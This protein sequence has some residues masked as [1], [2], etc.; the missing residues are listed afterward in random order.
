MF[1]GIKFDWFLKTAFI[2]IIMMPKSSLFFPIILA[3]VTILGTLA[4]TIH[5][6]WLHYACKPLIMLLL[7]LYVQQQY[8]LVSQASPIRW[9]LIGMVFALLG[10]VFLM[11]Q[12]VDLF[13]PGLGAFLVMQVCYSVAFVK[14]IQ[15]GGHAIRLQSVW[16]KALPF[17]VYIAVFL[18]LLRPVFAKNPALSALWWPVVVYAICLCTMGLLATQRQGLP[19]YVQIVTGALL[20]IFSDSVIAINKFLT[21][22]PEAPWLIML[23]YATA[24]YLIV[25][26]TVRAAATPQEAR[27]LFRI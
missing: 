10:D 2:L 21:P 6:R 8:R 1:I 13:A 4:D 20:F 23:T 16:P 19:Y 18:M 9:L 7:F 12:E 22:V 27:K 11:I 5:Y 26:G 14:S 15:Q 25:T 17:L 3:I 24:Q